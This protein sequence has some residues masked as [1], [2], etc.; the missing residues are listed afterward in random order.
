MIS[1]AHIVSWFKGKDKSLYSKGG[2]IF[3]L[4]NNEENNSTLTPFISQS[5]SFENSFCLSTEDIRYWPKIDP[6]IVFLSNERDKSL[7]A[8]D[9]RKTFPNSMFIGLTKE[10]LELE[11]GDNISF[12]KD[13]FSNCDSIACPYSHQMKDIYENILNLKIN[14]VH[15]P[16]NTKIFQEKYSTEK[17]KEPQIFL[18]R[19]WDGTRS[20]GVDNAFN[21]LY[22][23][24][25]KDVK[26]VTGTNDNFD[27]F[28]KLWSSSHILINLDPTVNYGKQSM[29]CAAL[30]VTHLGSHNDVAQNLWQGLTSVNVEFIKDKITNFLDNPQFLLDYNSHALKKLNNLYSIKS[31]KSKI[32]NLY[33]K[34]N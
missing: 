28:V 23:I 9:L 11:W 32:L 13:N 34:H 21:Y 24:F 29:E 16:F 8:Q 18:Y 19:H 15:Q 7:S 14:Y 31:F 22:S 27:E 2:K 3:N 25:H 12:I 33:N 30:G 4:H 26:F 17:T 20:L 5:L 10:P 6:D 1:V